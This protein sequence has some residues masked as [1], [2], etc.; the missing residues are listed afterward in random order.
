MTCPSA[1]F[2]HCHRVP[3]NLDAKEAITWINHGLIPDNF[4]IER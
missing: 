4:L 1:G 3:P 2:K